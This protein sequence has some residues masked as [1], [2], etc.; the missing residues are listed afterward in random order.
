MFVNG[1][2]APTPTPEFLTPEMG[3]CWTMYQDQDGAFWF[4][5]DNGVLRYKDGVR[6]RFTTKDGLAGDNTK[7]IIGD[8]ADGLWLGSYGGL[9]HFSNG[10]FTAWT[11]ADGLP[12]NTVRALK[13]DSDGTL[14]I[15]TYD[16]GL[17][18]FK[19]GKFTR[20]TTKDGLFDNGVFQILEDDFGRFW[21]SCNRGIYRVPKQELNDFADGKI[22]TVVSTPYGKSDGMDNVECNGGRWRRHQGS[23]RPTLVSD[24]QR[25]GGG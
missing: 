23:R 6:T 22:R 17:G 3:H 5:A 9:T 25:C 7:V 19:N 24:Y 20:Y 2:L 12:G 4:G 18:R 21:M 16:S 8:G 1:R 14:W 10:R 11:E 15:G 13:A